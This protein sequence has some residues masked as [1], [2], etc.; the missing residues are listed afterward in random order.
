MR[1]FPRLRSFQDGEFREALTEAGDEIVVKFAERY[2]ISAHRLLASRLHTIV[3]EHI[4]SVHPDNH[5]SK[6]HLEN[7]KDDIRTAINLLH[8]AN[9][10][11]GDLRTPNILIM[12]RSPGVYGGMLVDFDWCGEEGKARYRVGMVL[13]DRVNTAEKGGPILKEHDW[14]MFKMVFE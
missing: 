8:E 10:V 6:A 12:E 11:F 4:P 5:G 3:M 2:D 14:T 9:L 7:A 13:E 1:F